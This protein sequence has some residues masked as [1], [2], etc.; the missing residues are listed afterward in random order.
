MGSHL[1]DISSALLPWEKKKLMLQYASHLLVFGHFDQE[2][3]VGTTHA[4]AVQ[5]AGHQVLI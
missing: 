1:L 5:H 2:Q 3:E 4:N